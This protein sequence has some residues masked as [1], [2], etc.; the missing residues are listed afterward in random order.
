MSLPMPR[1]TVFWSTLPLS[2]LF[3][4]ITALVIVFLGIVLTFGAR[5]Y[6]LS[7]RCFQAVAAGD[8]LL[9]HFTAVKDHLTESLVSM[10][11]I[12][13][14]TFDEDL[15]RLEKEIEDLTA[16]PIVPESLKEGLLSRGE[17][18]DLGVRLRSIQERRVE[19]TAETTQLIRSLNTVNS[20]LQQFRIRL[21]DHTQALLLGLHRIGV[22]VLGLIVAMTCLLLFFLN[23]R[24]AVPLLNL[25]QRTNDLTGPEGE[26][27]RSCSMA[28]LTAQIND[29]LARNTGPDAAPAVLPD[30]AGEAKRYRYAAT[31][32]LTAEIASEVTNIVNGVINYTQTLVDV[33]E[34]AGHQGQAAVLSQSLLREE[35]KLAHLAA[36]LQRIGQWQQTRTVSVSLAQLFETLEV[37]LSKPLHVESIDLVLPD[38]CRHEVRIPAGDLWLVLVTVVQL[39]RRDFQRLQPNPKA[40]KRLSFSC[41]LHADRPQSLRLIITSNASSWGE[42]HR[43]DTAWPSLAFCDQILHSHQ[44]SLASKAGPDGPCIV[45][46]L[47]LRATVA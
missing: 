29:L 11:E 45:L 34:Q 23:Q 44:A 33:A 26:D 46:E 28:R 22:G 13:A 19:K 25:C 10:E 43:T 30:A 31:G 4:V 20:N 27:A 6:L 18:V 42:E 35:Q 37:I 9:F 24:V 39:G 1:T 15:Q 32:C 40:A 47:P 14:R 41:T 3:A 17:L 38:Q 16:N 36:A 7:N 5:Q 12:S 2:R 21:S 8:R